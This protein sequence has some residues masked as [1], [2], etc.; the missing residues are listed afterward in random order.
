MK[1]NAD[2][3]ILQSIQIVKLKTFNAFGTILL[4][5]LFSQFFAVSGLN[6]QTENTCFPCT[7][8]QMMPYDTIMEIKVQLPFSNKKTKVTVGV[9]NGL[10]Y[11]NYDIVLGS[12]KELLAKQEEKGVT[13]DALSSRWPNSTI[14]YTIDPAAGYTTAQVD[15]IE[16]AIAEINTK[17]NLNIILRTTETAYVEIYNGGDCS[18]VV[19][20]IGAKQ[21]LSLE[22]GCVVRGIIIHEFLHAAG[23]W[24]EQ[25]REDRDNHVVIH[26]ENIP[27]GMGNGNFQIVS[28]NS[29]TDQGTYDYGSVMHYFALAFSINGEPTISTIPPGIP[30]GNQDSL[31]T[32]DISAVNTIYPLLNTWTGGVDTDWD[33]PGNWSRLEVPLATHKVV[34]PDTTN[35]PVIL[36]GINALA[37]SMVVETGGKLTLHNGG[38]LTING[39]EHDGIFNEGTVENSGNITIAAS[40]SVAGRAIE[41]AGTFTNLACAELHIFDEVNNT[42][43]L[44][45]DGWFSAETGQ[46]H[47]NTGTFTNN[48]ILHFPIGNQ[49]P[50]VANNEIIIAPVST[51]N[52]SSISPALS[53]GS[54]LDFNI[55]GIFTDAA[56]TSSAGTF[57]TATNTFTPTATLGAGAHDF[58]VKMEDPVGSCTRIVPWKNVFC[59]PV[60]DTLYVN[61]AV[62]G[63][64]GDGTS[65]ADALDNFQDALDFAKSCG[66]PEIWVAAGIYQ[67]TKDAAGNLPTNPRNV[68]FFMDFDVEIYGGF[69]G[70]ETMLTQRNVAAN[71]TILSG[72]IG[73]AGNHSDNAY[74]VLHTKNLSSVAIVDG[75]T[76]RDGKADGA[77]FEKGN[78][79]GWYNDG[80]GSGN[81]SN[82]TV[83]NCL[84]LNN[85]TSGYGGA[86]FNVA[87]TGESSPNLTNC[88]F[89]GNSATLKGGAILN[90]GANG[91]SS[92]VLTNCSFAGNSAA[93]GG[94]VCNSGG[95]G[96]SAPSLNNCLF[97][98][99]TGSAKSLSNFLAAPQ[100]NYCLLEE[101]GCPAGATCDTN[102]IFGQN[103]FFA[104]V[105][106]HDL[107][108]PPCSPAV[109]VGNNGLNSS[110]LDLAGNPRAFD[111]DGNGTATIDLGAYEAQASIFALPTITTQPHSQVLNEGQTAVFNVEATGP[112]TLTYQWEKNGVDLPGE[113]SATLTINNVDIVHEGGY[114][115]QV[116]NPCRVLSNTATLTL[117]CAPSTVFVDAGATGNNTGGSWADA[118]TD[119]QTMVDSI[120]TGNCP[121][122]PET[123]VAAGTY[124]PSKNRAGE[125]PGNIR[126]ATFY[127]GEEIKMYGG[128]TGNETILSQ[129]NVVANPTILSGDIGIVGDA[130]DNAYTVVHTKNIDSNF[131][132][133]GFQIVDGN[134][135]G[136]GNFD[137]KASGGG[138]YNDGS[139]SGNLSNPNIANCRFLNNQAENGGAMFNNGISSGQSNPMLVNCQFL[140]N[141]A[142]NGGAM[143]NNGFFGESSPVLTNC[144]F[145][146]NVSNFDGGA[147][148]SNGF[149]GESSPVLTNCTFSNNTSGEN[150]GAIYILGDN[151]T[152]NS[153]FTNCQFFDNS[154][155]NHGGVLGYEDSSNGKP[156]FVNCTFF[157]NAAGAGGVLGIEV[158][159]SG[160]IPPEFKN[161]IAW[162]NSSTFGQ[163]SGGDGE[164]DIQYSLIQEGTCPA[165]ATCDGNT[166]FN[167]DPLFADTAN[168]NL[169]LL[170]GSPAIDAGT[171]TG[172]PATDFEGELRPNGAGVDMGYDEI[173]CTDTLYV[174]ASANGNNTGKSWDNAYTDLQPAID[175][176]RSGICSADLEIWV[177][178]GAYLPSKNDVGNIPT[179]PRNAT[180]YFDFDVKLYG[181]FA[182]TETQLSERDINKNP[183]IL[184]GDLGMAG[185]NSDNAYSVVHTRNVDSTFVMD[186]FHITDGHANGTGL[187]R[188]ESGG[189]W[190]NDGSGSGNDSS[191][192]V[193]GCTFSGNEAGHRGGGFYNHG[194]DG[195][196]SP[197][198]DRCVFSGNGA[199]TSGGAWHSNGNGGTTAP[200]LTNCLFHGNGSAATFKGGAISI[201]DADTGAPS[202]TNCT[203]YGNTAQFGGAV[204]LTFWDNG[205]IPSTFKN[206]IAW[207][208]SSTFGQTGGGL[209][210]LDIQHSL[211]Q[212]GACPTGAT[213]DGG[214]IFNQDPLFVDANDGEFELFG[215]SP[216]I[217]EGTIAGAPPTDFEGAVRPNGAGVDMGFDEVYCPPDSVIYVDA[218]A[219]GANNG[220]SWDDAF[221]DFQKAV[222]WA[223]VNSCASN[224]QIW[225]AAGSYLPTKDT[226]GNIPPNPRNAKFYFDFDYE[227]YGGFA[228]GETAILERDFGAN[229][230][231]LS[232]D[233][234]VEGD[235]SD[236][237][238][239]V[240]MTKN[241]TGIFLMDGFQIVDGHANGSGQTERSNGGGWFNDGN[242]S[243][244]SSSPS[245]RN[246]VFKNN[247]AADFG[248][249]ME[250]L[251]HGGDASPLFSN[252][253]FLSNTATFGGGVSNN[254]RNSG[255]SQPTFTDC[256]FKGNEATT[257]GGSMF[258][259][260]SNGT[261]SPSSTNCL[262]SG[263]TSLDAGGVAGS[264]GTGGTCSSTYT[265]CT[266]SGNS[267]AD[268]TSGVLINFGA[269]P[270]LLNSII[271]GNSSEIDDFGTS[272]TTVT[273]CLF[274][275]GFAGGTNIIDAD[276]LFV[277]Q[278][279]FNNAPTLAG[280]LHFQANSPALDTGNNVFLPVGVITDLDGFNRISNGTVDLGTYE[281]VDC[282]SAATRT[283][284]GAMDSL[285]AEPSNWNCGVPDLA[286]DVLIPDGT[287]IVILQSG[288]IGYCW[289]FTLETGAEMD[290]H[291]GA[292]LNV[293]E[294]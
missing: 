133:D 83:A 177:A 88:V 135:N 2:T 233:I 69:T 294:Q 260:G 266:F 121:D 162:G 212:E 16:A 25:S 96:T 153:T 10:A 197:L 22:F 13:I 82:P 29:N 194:Q 216:A 192:T 171:A 15:T 70:T 55:L 49:V 164:L 35:H 224:N 283:W 113:T 210:G 178:A 227:I 285:W 143:L 156:Q 36:N 158:W 293:G 131:V 37:R 209:G 12:I 237:A 222:Q 232:G 74:T 99:N 142:E 107:Q 161:C 265:N 198:M 264:D 93:D 40:Q 56:A 259:W 286:M 201:D 182:G 241:R 199:G 116:G 180:F 125:V 272:T 137:P 81:V 219:K 68:T 225:V 27:G 53:L 263:N 66:I 126:D 21:Q 273:N 169:R 215:N 101:N 72:D 28:P 281:S 50:N 92:P 262:Y 247:I 236:N 278:P 152:T 234:G 251:G 239:T 117:N 30:I 204:G 64:T 289:Q 140:N 195:A 90:L 175:L 206:C 118:F 191:P 145:A 130:S 97:W 238:Y 155:T 202:F 32:G 257:Y 268:G 79:A 17:T 47:L 139:A 274:E 287:P 150:G 80:S 185:D 4:W 7:E 186:G 277:N 62:S 129:R 43:T 18:S 256:T 51:A 276:P 220:S 190:F 84:F 275:G 141:Q 196:A 250:N 104:D 166:I 147:M 115:V 71:P 128:F 98:G 187:L 229:P 45:N 134:A 11:Y 8:S 38:N 3:N 242:G 252:C 23:F 41:N 184:N 127:F 65:W 228:G 269:T 193:R 279:D 148:F 94:A 173:H 240:V 253:T 254:G 270:S 211:I 248:G 124:R 76:I 26:W 19:G 205:Q 149:T 168:A 78:G 157:N 159:D 61:A 1:K 54:P 33:E 208:N 214:T 58:F 258:N 226:P 221:T 57:D 230:T 77:G 44:T 109:E 146:N 249:G 120:L 165:G 200:A 42:D 138:W 60:T 87:R 34:I 235:S 170:F 172:A 154:A 267:S 144:T 105:P 188:R 85:S 114:T 59:C 20:S 207:G 176:A 122:V 52:C 46:T 223:R 48:G 179:D 174:D 217:D 63:G 231:I 282:P 123:W 75:F 160:Q 108:I 189:G 203:F 24:H 261:S 136:G 246:C 244:N 5:L 119:L 111:A 112:G 106:N 91:I 102:T 218:S 280:N 9:R 284:T 103:P 110:T 291:A 67:P 271:W 100:V 290:V 39:S 163:T 245:I 181:G 6:A 288:E 243:G 292:E 86:M 73:T 151:G 89:S 132:L 31:S 167:Q 255:N 95:N 213:C 183:T 14:P